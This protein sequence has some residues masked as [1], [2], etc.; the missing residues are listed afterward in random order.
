M[1]L[2]LTAVVSGSVEVLSIISNNVNGP[3]RKAVHVPPL[4]EAAGLRIWRLASCSIMGR[5]NLDFFLYG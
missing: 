5:L 4:R 2:F 1:R 3:H